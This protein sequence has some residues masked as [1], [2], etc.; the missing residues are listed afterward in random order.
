MRILAIDPGGTSG[1]VV[2][3]CPATKEPPIVLHFWEEQSSPCERVALLLAW[4]RK[5]RIERVVVEDYR[6]YA[7]H[8]GHH[9]GQHL[10]VSEY[11][12]AI[13][14]VCQLVIPRID[15]YRVQPSSKGKW[16]KARLDAKFPEHSR[17]EGVHA[18][19]ALVIG[20]VHI[21]AVGLWEVM[22]HD[23]V[24]ALSGGSH[25]TYG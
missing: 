15:M 10:Y 16:P 3:D 6:I 18:H 5:A 9:V 25:T 7:A 20:L 12:G 23:A 22:C 4:F 17:V 24:I 8:T 1:Y 14:A 11:I 21:E 13:E 2:L 19:D